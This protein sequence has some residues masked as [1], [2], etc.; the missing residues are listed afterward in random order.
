MLT[1]QRKTYYRKSKYEEYPEDARKI[2]SIFEREQKGDFGALNRVFFVYEANRQGKTCTGDQTPRHVFHIPELGEMYPGAKFIHM[3]RDPRAVLL[4]QKRKWKAGL[5]WQ[6]PKF[7]V[8]RTFVNYHPITTTII[9]KK[10]ISAGFAAQHAIP[11]DTMKSI[12][13]E[14]LVESPRRTVEEICDF[15]EVKFFLR[16]L[17][18]E[19]E[20]SGNA[21]DDRAKGISVAVSERWMTELSRTEVFL[22]EKLAGSQM[23]RLGY[24]LTR[25]NPNFLKLVAY[26]CTWPLQLSLALILN[27]GRMGKPI[28]YIS[29]RLFQKQPLSFSNSLTK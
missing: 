22:A 12:F 3:V 20:L 1:I 8:L 21:R 28:S 25:F 24:R 11:S 7:E 6:Q 14:N 16:M 10:A 15:L 29:K 5:R 4:S 26:F 9:W 23:R 19:V 18:V 27:L 13:F 2:I 17:D